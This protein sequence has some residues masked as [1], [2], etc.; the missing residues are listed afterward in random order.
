[1]AE[2]WGLTI[3]EAMAVKLPIICPIHTSISEITNDGKLVTN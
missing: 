2:G 1:M 3:T